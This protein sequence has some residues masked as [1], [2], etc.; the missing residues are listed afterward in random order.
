MVQRVAKYILLIVLLLGVSAADDWAVRLAAFKSWF[1]TH[2]GRIH[3]N[4]RLDISTNIHDGSRSVRLLTRGRIQKGQPVIQVP[5]GLLIRPDLE[6]SET[7]GSSLDAF[8]ETEKLCLYILHLQEAPQNKWKPYF[9]M[10]PSSLS[11]SAL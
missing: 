1:A 9:D 3:R 8:S 5:E 2:G 10:L 4:V 6:W 11:A 7:F